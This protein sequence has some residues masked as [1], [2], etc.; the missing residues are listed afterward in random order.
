MGSSLRTW[1]NDLTAS[2]NSLSLKIEL[3]VNICSV[4]CLK[5]Y[6]QDPLSHNAFRT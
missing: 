5:N 3:Q 2:S 6:K 1:L 4:Y